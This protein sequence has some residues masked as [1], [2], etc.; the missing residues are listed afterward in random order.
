[1]FVLGGGSGAGV[2][3]DEAKEWAKEGR[4]GMGMKD[5]KEREGEADQ[6]WKEWK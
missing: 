4:D 6:G 2:K 3:K 1:M 5:V